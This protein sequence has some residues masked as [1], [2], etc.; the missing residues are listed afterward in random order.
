MF[1]NRAEAAKTA[2]HKTAHKQN[3]KNDKTES[4]K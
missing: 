4:N 2:I 1:L 3:N